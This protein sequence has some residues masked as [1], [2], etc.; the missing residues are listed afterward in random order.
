M[1]GFFSTIGNNITTDERS[2][3]LLD[4]VIYSKTTKLVFLGVMVFGSIILCG[5]CLYRYYREDSDVITL[6][7]P[8]KSQVAPLSAETSNVLPFS[9]HDLDS[10]SVRSESSD[11]LPTTPNNSRHES[12]GQEDFQ[13]LPGVP[14]SE[15]QRSTV[16]INPPIDGHRV[17]P[18]TMVFYNTEL[19]LGTWVQQEDTSDIKELSLKSM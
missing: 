14:E 18:T 13:S 4:N 17:L 5:W 2:D 12:V 7:P 10:I 8:P 19:P 9:N 15:P 6:V 16:S 11:I 3:D 1:Y